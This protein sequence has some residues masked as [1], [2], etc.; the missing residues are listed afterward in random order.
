MELERIGGISM[1][2]CRFEIR[3]KIDDRDGLKRASR[4]YDSSET[5]KKP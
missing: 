3:R 1:R 2:D 5:H 4:D